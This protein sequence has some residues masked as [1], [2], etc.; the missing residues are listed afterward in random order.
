MDGFSFHSL[1]KFFAT[2]LFNNGADIRTVQI[3]GNW[4][5]ISVVERYAKLSDTRKK[6][7]FQAVARIVNPE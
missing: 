7:A 6:Q 3:C 5:S 2:T 1:R 4:K